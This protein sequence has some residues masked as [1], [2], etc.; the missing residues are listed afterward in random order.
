MGTARPGLASSRGPTARQQEILRLLAEDLSCAEIGRF[1]GI[2]A[3]T[4]GT[5]LRALANRLGLKG[6]GEVR[7]H[8]R[9]MGDRIKP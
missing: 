8:A 6:T 3:V 7:A 9:G 5:H 1:L 2:S 4:V